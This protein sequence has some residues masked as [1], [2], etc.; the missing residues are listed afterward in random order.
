[1]SLTP[2]SRFQYFIHGLL[3]FFTMVLWSVVSSHAHDIE[4]MKHGVVKITAHVNGQSKVGTGIII[5]QES[6][7]L[8]IVTASHVIE[9]DPRPLV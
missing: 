8:F 5:R 3:A 7:A 6:D 9:G 1:M 4:G 2:P